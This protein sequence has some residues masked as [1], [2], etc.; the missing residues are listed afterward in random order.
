VEGSLHP[1][2]GSLQQSR[3][4]TV[5]PRSQSRHTTRWTLNLLALGC[6]LV[7]A[8]TAYNGAAIVRFELLKARLDSLRGSSIDS[9]LQPILAWKN[10]PGVAVRARRLAF[11]VVVAETPADLSGVETALNDLVKEA[12]TAVDAWQARVDYL[13]A[14]R[15]P[16]ER[17]LASLRM[18]ALTGS[19]E[20]FAMVERASFGLEHWS[21]L[22]EADR[23]AIIR[24]VLGTVLVAELG[25]GTRYRMVLAEK[26]ELE[27][28]D[29]KATF[30]ASGLGSKQILEAL[31]L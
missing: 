15:A 25:R 31:G 20:G 22:P 7:F 1:K 24:D 19:H 26:S 6:V 4:R 27:R 28:Q 29:I 17:V 16:M 10:T 3:R 5:T 11:A 21:E 18:S 2:G 14:R 9:M 8:I 12:P 13:Q 30:I 23:G